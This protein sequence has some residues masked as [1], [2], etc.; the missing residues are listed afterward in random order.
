LISADRPGRNLAAAGGSAARRRAA[1]PAPDRGDGRW[2]TR[3]YR[4]SRLQETPENRR[5]TREPSRH[6]AFGA[7][8]GRP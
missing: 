8:F 7:A 5:S 6:C 2:P 3:A 1:R 4:R